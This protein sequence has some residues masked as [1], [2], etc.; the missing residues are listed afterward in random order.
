VYVTDQIP[1]SMPRLEKFLNVDFGFGEF[2]VE[3]GIQA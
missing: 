3:C 1:R 2:G